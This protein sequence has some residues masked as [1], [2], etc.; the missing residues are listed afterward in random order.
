[1]N[2]EA[3][4]GARLRMLRKWRKMTLAELADRVGVSKSHLSMAE[5]GESGERVLAL[6]NGIDESRLAVRQ[7]RHANMLAD[8]GRA[9]ARE[10]KTRQ[11]AV[12]WLR[13]AEHI[14]P[15]RIRNS[16]P[17]RE[18]VGVLLNQPLP[19]TA[20]RELRGMAARMGIPH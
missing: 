14:A 1:M 13:R 5:R 12:R 2:D 3:T 17:V 11:K 18:T 19:G 6:A 10:R 20:G 15:Q 4:I 9:L 8:V 16:A 7:S